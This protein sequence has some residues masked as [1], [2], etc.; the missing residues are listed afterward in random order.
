[1]NKLTMAQRQQT[2]AN[3]QQ[4]PSL[5]KQIDS[6]INIKWYVFPVCIS[7]LFLYIELYVSSVNDTMPIQRRLPKENNQLQIIFKNQNIIMQVH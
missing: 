6:K 1:M 7:E 5:K 3:L 2:H 4:H